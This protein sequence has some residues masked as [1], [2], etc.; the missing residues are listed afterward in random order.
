LG[1]VRRLLDETQ[2]LAEQVE[3]TLLE[4]YGIQPDR[5]YRYDAAEESIFE[6]PSDR[7]RQEEKPRLHR[8]L[9]KEPER[10]RFLALLQARESVRLQ[11]QG[12]NLV[13]QRKRQELETVGKALLD[14]YAMS[15]D[16]VYIV[17]SDPGLFGR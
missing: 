6:M 2:A 4:E 9:T 14:N 12:L 7:A 17:E 11:I 5:Q 16:R 13:L 1:I 8:R 10:V 15:R 3:K